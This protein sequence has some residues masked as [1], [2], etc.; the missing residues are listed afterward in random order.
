M[1]LIGIEDDGMTD[2]VPNTGNQID[3]ALFGEAESDTRGVFLTTSI[4][5]TPQSKPTLPFSTHCS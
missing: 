3:D 1:A 5:T 2:L 4:P